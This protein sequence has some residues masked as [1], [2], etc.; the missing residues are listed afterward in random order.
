MEFAKRQ[1]RQL[2]PKHDRSIGRRP[3]LFKNVLCQI[4][5]DDGNLFHGCLPSLRGCIATNLA[6]CDAIGEGWH[7]SHLSGMSVVAGHHR[8]GLG[9]TR[10]DCRSLMPYRLASRLRP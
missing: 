3:M 8:G 4:D 9:H 6:Y 5:S 7:L 2:P 1:T 10:M